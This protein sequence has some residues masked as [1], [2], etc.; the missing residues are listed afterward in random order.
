MCV[1]VCYKNDACENECVR[2]FVCVRSSTCFLL[3]TISHEV[4]MRFLLINYISYRL[5]AM[6]GKQARYGPIFCFLFGFFL[7]SEKVTTLF[8]PFKWRFV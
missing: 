2:V 4:L 3:C 1:H 5:F 7:S 6:M 8:T